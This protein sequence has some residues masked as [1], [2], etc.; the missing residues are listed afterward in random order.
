ML[1]FPNIKILP[2]LSLQFAYAMTANSESIFYTLIVTLAVI[3]I[4]NLG[5]LAVFKKKSL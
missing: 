4:F 2:Y 5:G 3:V 1:L